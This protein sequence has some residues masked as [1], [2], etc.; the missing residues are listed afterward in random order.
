MRKA[1]IQQD[2]PPA[3]TGTVVNIVT[4]PGDWNNQPGQWQLPDGHKVTDLGSGA[5]GDYWDGAQFVKPEPAPAPTPEEE[6]AAWLAENK[7]AD[8]LIRA[9]NK[10]TNDATHL[11]PNAN[12]SN[13]ALVA[14]IKVNLV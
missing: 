5:V 13:A 10:P 9:L 14:K 3:L 7:F 4:L 12:L 1:L 6:I 2:N 11:P 8:A